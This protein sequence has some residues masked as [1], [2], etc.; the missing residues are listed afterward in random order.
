MVYIFSLTGI[1]ISS[2][3]TFSE[4]A[5]KY[6][7]DDRFRALEKM[8]EREQLFNEYLVEMKKTVTKHKDEFKASNKTKAEKVRLWC[9][10][11]SVVEMVQ[12]L[13]SVVVMF[14][15]T[16]EDGLSEHVGGE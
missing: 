2:R 14:V 12:S 1:L 13:T 7:K 8:R 3:S 9:E 10:A 11:H 16:G 5:A 4:F 6:S 15:S